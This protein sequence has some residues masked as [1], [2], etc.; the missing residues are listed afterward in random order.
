MVKPAGSRSVGSGN[1]RKTSRHVPNRV[2]TQVEAEPT[3]ENLE[4]ISLP[5]TTSLSRASVFKLQRT[6]GNR[7]TTAV[8]AQRTAG[9]RATKLQRQTRTAPSDSL[10]L[11]RDEPDEEIRDIHDDFDRRLGFFHERWANGLAAF[12]T[13]MQFSS[14]QEAASNFDEAIA[15]AVAEAL[16]DVAIGATAAIPV[17]GSVVSPALSVAKAAGKAAFDESARVEGASGERAIAEYVNRMRTAIQRSRETMSDRHSAGF[18]SILD[19]YRAAAGASPADVA[20]PNGPA[21]VHGEAARWIRRYRQALA[22]FSRATPREDQFR[23]L[24]TERFALTGRNVG[25]VT[26]GTYRPSGMLTIEMEVK[27]SPRGEWTVEDIDDH[28]TLGTSA[29]NP[30]RVAQNL[31]DSLGVLPVWSHANLP[32]QVK[33]EIDDESTDT[34]TETTISVPIDRSEIFVRTRGDRAT[35]LQAAREPVLALRLI[36]IAKIEG[37]SD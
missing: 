31:M 8:L 16:L 1:P 4:S 32:K 23:Q 34:E 14:E 2:A 30:E 36:D 27:I 21:T 15:G 5:T 29:P 12:L 10:R 3:S 17:I 6:I 9:T 33:I 28:W 26:Q 18:S 24:I 35:G 37:S 13:T 19:S 25:Y 7:A 20:Q 22:A 11:T